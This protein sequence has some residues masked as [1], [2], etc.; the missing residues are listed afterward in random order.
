MPR[1]IFD[2]GSWLDL[3]DVGNVVGVAPAGSVPD[4]VSA[5]YVDPRSPVL[6]QFIQAA[7]G[8]ISTAF[9]RAVNPP[10]RTTAATARTVS[11]NTGL[12]LLVLVG[13]LVLPK[14]LQG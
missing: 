11:N 6:D 3:D 4:L 8:N 5:A 12:L 1:Q 10:P 13:V 7:L 2:D 9:T 14:L